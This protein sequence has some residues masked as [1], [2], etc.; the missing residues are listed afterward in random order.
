M[1][2]ALGFTKVVNRSLK[3]AIRHYCWFHSQ[4]TSSMHV[5][6]STTIR[7]KVSFMSDSALIYIDGAEV[8][9]D[10]QNFN[11][12][13]QIK[14]MTT[15]LS[16]IMLQSIHD[17]SRGDYSPV[18]PIRASF[19]FD[20]YFG[21]EN[22]LVGYLS[23]SVGLTKETIPFGIV[24]KAVVRAYDWEKKQKW[25]G[26]SFTPETY[27]Y[28]NSNMRGIIDE[29]KADNLIVE[30]KVPIECKGEKK[31]IPSY[32]INFNY[33]GRFDELYQSLENS[34]SAAENDDISAKYR[35]TK[36]FLVYCRDNNLVRRK[37]T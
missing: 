8:R 27:E 2:D 16:N 10:V 23:S 35:A 5:R 17:L 28:M 24:G 33:E 14:L 12:S 11:D 37:N 26:A 31:E 9:T 6:S 25:L 3:D 7:P 30:Y 32:A 21:S 4:V 1:A 19:S 20:E 36:D 29:L 18:V 22:F 13:I 15:M 34:E